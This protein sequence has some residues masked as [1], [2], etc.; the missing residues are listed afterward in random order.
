MTI[1]RF[2]LR[3]DSSKRGVPPNVII[4]VPSAD[5]TVCPVFVGES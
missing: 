4:S 5:L 1:D 3:L 2:G